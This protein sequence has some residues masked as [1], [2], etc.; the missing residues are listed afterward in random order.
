M[1]TLL[2]DE[3]T[4]AGAGDIVSMLGSCTAYAYGNFDGASVYLEIGPD[5]SET[6][7]PVRGVRF[8][9]PAAVV[10]APFGPYDIRAV[11]DHPGPQT[12]VT[13]ELMFIQAEEAEPVP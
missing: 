11:L 5:G 1:P 7:A 13:V 6:M 9:S 8:D 2:L 12:E 3:E 10:I 4:E